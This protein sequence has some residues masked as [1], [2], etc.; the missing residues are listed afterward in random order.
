MLFVLAFKVIS[1]VKT[2]AVSANVHVWCRE[3]VCNCNVQSGTSNIINETPL[4]STQ[5]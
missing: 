2:S 5:N 1:F 4:G 3:N